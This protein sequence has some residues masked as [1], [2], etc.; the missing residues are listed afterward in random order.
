MTQPGNAV[1]VQLHHGE[2]KGRTINGMSVENP[3]H[4]EAASFL[5]RSSDI[6]AIP[7]VSS[8]TCPLARE[9]VFSKEPGFASLCDAMTFAQQRI[10]LT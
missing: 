1:D 5:V 3:S 2:R 4:R 10:E 8:L 9:T 7:R 6:E